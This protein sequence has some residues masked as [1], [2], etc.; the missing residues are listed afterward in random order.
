M[1]EEALNLSDETGDDI[2]ILQKTIEGLRLKH[3]VRT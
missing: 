3:E 2:E 1:D